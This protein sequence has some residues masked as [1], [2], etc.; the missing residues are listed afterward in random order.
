MKEYPNP[1]VKL[2]EVL[3]GT[4]AGSTNIVLTEAPV[5][6]IKGRGASPAGINNSASNELGKIPAG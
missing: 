2:V 6:V 1:L 4:N 5:V 3:S